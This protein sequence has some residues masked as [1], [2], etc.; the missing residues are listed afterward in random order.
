VPSAVFS[1][2]AALVLGASAAPPAQSDTLVARPKLPLPL[3]VRSGPNGPIVAR[4]KGATEFGSP[5]AFSVVRRSGRWVAVRTASVPNGRVGWIDTARTPLGFARTQLSVEVDL[6]RRLLVLRRGDT[7]L[8]RAVVAIGRAGS[9]TPTGRFAVT[10]KLAGSRYGSSYGCC[11][12]ALSGTQ[13]NLP[14]GWTGG[15]RLAI[16]GGPARTIGTDVSAG[17]LHA[18]PD[19]LR[20]LMRL[21]PLGTP[22]TIRA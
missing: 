13:P 14:A 22:V 18:S 20:Y 4:F 9:T 6:S 3:E 16:H 11:I 15:N 7:V 21:V 1:A 12:L 17:C 19:D 5:L 10:D 8:H 2:V